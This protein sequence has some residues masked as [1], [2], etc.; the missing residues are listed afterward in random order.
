M[1]RV[2][3]GHLSVLKVA[4]ARAEQAIQEGRVTSYGDDEGVR[5]VLREAVHAHFSQLSQKLDEWDALTARLAS[6]EQIVEQHLR[7]SSSSL[8][9]VVPDYD[10]D[11]IVRF[12][13]DDICQRARN[14]RLDDPVVFQ[15]TGYDEPGWVMPQ[16]HPAAWLLHKR[17]PS[18]S[19]DEW[20]LR[21][22]ERLVPIEEITDQARGWEESRLITKL[23]Q[24]QHASR[25]HLIEE[26]RLLRQRE[27]VPTVSDCPICSVNSL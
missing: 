26:L 19:L 22:R 14:A 1:P 9:I 24:E 4:L 11:R 7:L 12:I 23:V 2:P 27:I 21:V 15:W 25:P 8:G 13:R 5:P 6:N 10:V 20:R 18:V 17:E 3:A 16:G